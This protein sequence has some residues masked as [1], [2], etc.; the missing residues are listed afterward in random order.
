M[1]EVSYFISVSWMFIQ[2][3]RG[4]G[5]GAEAARGSHLAGVVNECEEVDECMWMRGDS[6]HCPSCMQH[7][8]VA[9]YYQ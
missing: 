5:R 1:P 4:D 8:V 6:G 2:V 9:G 3:R 7:A